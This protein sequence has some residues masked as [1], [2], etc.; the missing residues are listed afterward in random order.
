[1]ISFDLTGKVALVTGGNGGLGLDCA[2]ALAHYGADIA[3]CARNMDKAKKAQEE[4]S[5]ESGRRVEIYSLDVL[6][7]ESIKVCVQSVMKDFGKID[8]LLNNSGTFER[9]LGGPEEHTEAQ[10]DNVMDTDVKG[11]F[12]MAVE[13][14]KAYMKEH[15]GKIINMAS[16]GGMRAAAISP[17]YN[18]AKAAVI[19]M[20]EVLALSW[21]PYGVF[22]NQISPGQII[23][24]MGER[25][26]QDRVEGFMRRIP[27]GRCGDHED[28]MGA[29][30]FLASDACTYCQGANIVCDGGLILGFDG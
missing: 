8:I 26:P 13:V 16:I 19:R 6:S 9:S 12:F 30:V 11:A 21:A 25:T 3:I 20:T 5:I 14:F 4:L 7:M 28:L 29:C 15:G 1:M 2:R 10:W 22:V 23:S 18:I 27:Q 24:G 17:S